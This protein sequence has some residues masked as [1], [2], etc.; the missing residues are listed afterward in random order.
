MSNFC[1][2][3]VFFLPFQGRCPKVRGVIS[4][5]SG[6][7]SG[8]C[9]QRGGTR[10]SRVIKLIFSFFLLLFFISSCH[11][12]KKITEPKEDPKETVSVEYVPYFEKYALLIGVKSDELTNGKL[13][14]YI[15]GW[16]GVPY[17]WGGNDTNGVDCSGF[18]NLVYLNVFQKQL[19]RSAT[20]IIGECDEINKEDLKEGDLV[21]FDISGKNSHIGIYL[22]NDK[23]IHA[24]SSKGVMISD[25]TQSYWVKNWGRAGKVK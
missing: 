6:E 22:A 4:P 25:L 15:D 3:Y 19:K 14:K 7:M 23:F 9:G 11:N 17:K 1:K 5:L 2:T 12:K 21:F 18:V 8:F 20:D 10:Y 24:S 13:Y 16:M